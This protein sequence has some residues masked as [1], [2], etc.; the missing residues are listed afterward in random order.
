VS[1]LALG[2]MTFGTERTGERESRQIFDAYVEGGGTFV[3]TADV[4]ADGRS[5][6]LVGAFVAER[7]MR[8]RLIIATKFGFND[9]DVSPLAGGNG[10]KNL[11]RA[12]AGS[13]RRLRTDYVDL[14][15]MH[16]WDRVTP[17][18]EVLQTLGDFVRA[19]KIRYFGFSDVPAWYAARAATLAAA[20]A[21]PGPVALQLEYSLTERSIERE[22]VPAALELCLGITPWSPLAAGFLTGKFARDDVAGDAGRAG[23]KF[24]ERNWRTLD[25]L[26]EV[27][28]D[29]GETPANVA[30]AWASGRPGIS[31]AIL[32]AT[33]VEQLKA[34]LSSWKVAMTAEHLA[35]LDVVSAL[36]AAQPYDLFSDDSNRKVFAG[37]TVERPQ[38][39][40]R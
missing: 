32:G 16:V 2:T 37:A 23:R 12:I 21:V 25:V 8:D 35:R 39:S 3:D 20:Y 33:T 15:W 10:R 26:R 34:N 19:G 14:Y 36:D 1:P 27:A 28:N 18:E 31:S 24:A 4:Y 5:E 38:V 11:H 13:L 22:H 30:L 7:H 9:E 6:E 17:V 29:M 40:V